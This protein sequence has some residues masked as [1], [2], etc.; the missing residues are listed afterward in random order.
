LIVI[1]IQGNWFTNFEP[2]FTAEAQRT[3]SL[4]R[5]PPRFLR[6][7]CASAVRE[8]LIVDYLDL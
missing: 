8:V 5:E 3:Q 1:E 2:G 6:A 4:R 7:L